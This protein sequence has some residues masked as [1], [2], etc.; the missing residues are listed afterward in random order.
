M[1]S[2]WKVRLAR[3]KLLVLFVVTALGCGSLSRFDP[4]LKEEVER[5]KILP[6]VGW[7]G[8]LPSGSFRAQAPERITI[9]H[10]RSTPPAGADLVAY[11]K[12][13]QQKDVQR[14]WGDLGAHYYI[15]PAGAIY[16]SRRIVLKGRMKEEKRLDPDGHV[17]V[18]LIGDYSTLPLSEPFQE[19]FIALVGWLLQHHAIPLENLRGLSD[20]I[21][22]DSP[23]RNVS[24]WMKSPEFEIRLKEHLG[25][26]LEVPTPT[27]AGTVDSE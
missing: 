12:A 11:M 18:M 16:Q 3:K 23:G 8:V 22:T 7:G 5:P 10:T 21:R 4:V 9:L 19:K 17:L 26:P 6:A 2:P 20:Y 15:D 27:P 1:P 14:G 13:L 25:I 24:E